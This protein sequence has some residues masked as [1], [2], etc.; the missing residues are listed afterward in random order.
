MNYF[1]IDDWSQ[2]QFFTDQ[3]LDQLN[4]ALTYL[5]DLEGVELDEV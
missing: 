2:E 3:E 4:L 5:Y 1:D